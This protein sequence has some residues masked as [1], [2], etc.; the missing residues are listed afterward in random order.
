MRSVEQVAVI[1]L[2][3]GRL[4]NEAHRKMELREKNNSH[5]FGN[6]FL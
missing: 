3:F 6:F 5:E 4:K 2:Y 1:R